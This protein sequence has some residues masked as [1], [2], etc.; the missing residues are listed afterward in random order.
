MKGPAQQTWG[1]DLEIQVRSTAK[2]ACTVCNFSLAV[3]KTHLEISAC[4]DRTAEHKA[5]ILRSRLL[6]SLHRAHS[7]TQ[8]PAPDLVTALFLLCLTVLLALLAV[9]FTVFLTVFDAFLPC[10]PPSLATVS[11][12]NHRSS[13]ISRHRGCGDCDGTYAMNSALGARI[14]RGLHAR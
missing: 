6:V 3:V 12:C 2:T 14:D 11:A 7:R 5:F 1:Y 8:L 9:C 10:V 13:R 4:L